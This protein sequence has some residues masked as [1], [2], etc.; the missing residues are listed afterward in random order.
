[1]L[2]SGAI[3]VAI[4]DIALEGETGTDLIP[5][6]REVD[7]AFPIVLFTASDT[8]QDAGGAD[9]VL[10]KSRSPLEDLVDVT[11]RLVSRKKKAA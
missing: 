10:V 8:M 7:P 9:R 6:L 3:D 4:V 2:A 5:L 1:M 11:L